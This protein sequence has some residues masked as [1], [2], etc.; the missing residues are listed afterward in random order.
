MDHVGPCDVLCI[1]AVDHEGLATLFVFTMDHGGLCGFFSVDHGGPCEFFSGSRR[2][3][4]LFFKKKWITEGL[5]TF[6]FKKK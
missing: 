5:A 2:A 4:R 1:F 6:F 3:L